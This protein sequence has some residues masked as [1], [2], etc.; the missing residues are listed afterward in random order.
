MF[1][2][3]GTQ[4]DSG[5]HAEQFNKGLQEAMKTLASFLPGDERAV[6]DGKR[7]MM[8]AATGAL[9]F[10]LIDHVHKY[11]LLDPYHTEILGRNAE[12]FL[13][14]DYDRTLTA[15]QVKDV[16]DWVEFIEQLKMGWNRMVAAEQTRMWDHI[17]TIYMAY[18]EFA[19]I[20]TK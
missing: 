7:K 16:R 6:I 10:L 14:L 4:Q 9:P 17:E 1:K 2:R 19:A 12:F 20:E 3:K 13:C 15:N 5:H 18:L 11:K 8:S